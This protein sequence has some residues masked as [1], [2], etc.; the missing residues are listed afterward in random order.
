MVLWAIS[1]FAAGGSR[2]HV[3][4]V[5]SGASAE[6]VL[7]SLQSVALVLARLLS[8]RALLSL[9]RSTPHSYTLTNVTHGDVP[10]RP[11]LPRGEGGDFCRTSLRYH[12]PTACG[13]I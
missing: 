7:G 2:V 5:R 11:P 1:I 9:N 4:G 13:L 12:V 3:H 8:P 10:S 6:E